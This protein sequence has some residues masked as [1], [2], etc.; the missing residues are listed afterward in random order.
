M[1]HHRR[2]CCSDVGSFHL[3]FVICSLLNPLLTWGTAL[4][5]EPDYARRTFK[6]GTVE[7]GISAGFWQAV[8]AVNHPQSL[9][10]S[11]VFVLPRI[12]VVANDEFKAGLLSGNVEFAVEPFIARFIKPFAAEAIGGTALVTYN[13]VSF[14]RW[15][16]FWDAGAGLLWTNLAPRIPEQ[17]TTVNFVLETGPGVHFFITSSLTIRTGV[18]FYHISNAGTGDRNTGLNGVLGTVGL[19]WLF[20]SPSGF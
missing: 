5:D 20:A 10:R 15:V 16:P 9:D 2:T 12:G 3:A 14:G 19:S 4:A 6:A 1:V 18:R 13:F 17:S 11:A 8:E 7:A